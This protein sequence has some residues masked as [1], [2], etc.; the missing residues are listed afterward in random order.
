[1]RVLITGATGFIGSH[2]ADALHARGYRLRCLVRR[3]SNLQWIKELPVEYCYGD[4]FDES[5]LRKA[6]SE[7]DYIF[8]FAGVTKAKTKAEYFKGNHLATRNLLHAVV[9]MNGGLS[10]FIH[11]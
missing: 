1:M 8:H 6:V 5:A 7:V 2:C 4:L 10:R 11:I 3:S 9:E